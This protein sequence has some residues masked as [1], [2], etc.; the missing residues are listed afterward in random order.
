VNDEEQRA[1]EERVAKGRE[2]ARGVVG[3]TVLHVLAG[4]CGEARRY[5]SGEE[6]DRH[7]PSPD[8]VAR[9]GHPETLGPVLD[10]GGNTFT[11]GEDDWP[12]FM[13]LT[14]EEARTRDVMRTAFAAA[15]REIAQY[16]AAAKVDQRR[17]IRIL[18]ALLR[19]QIAR[20]A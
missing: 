1:R 6:G 2:W 5:W 9:Y 15:M 10:V 4:A 8:V 3:K 18:S 13:V 20:L 17:F 7:R 12:N 16:A 19:E 14:P 11:A